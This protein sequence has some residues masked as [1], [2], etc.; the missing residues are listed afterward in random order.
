MEEKK[1]FNSKRRR[2]KK[3]SSTEKINVKNI[4]E[5]KGGKKINKW[6][7]NYF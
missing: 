5:K 2:Y 6:V 4:N 1:Q 7:I 3:T